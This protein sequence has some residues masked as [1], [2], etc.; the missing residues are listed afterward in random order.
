[1]VR[2]I[3]P[4]YF[5]AGAVG[6]ISEVGNFG[7]VAA[8]LYRTFG[9]ASGLYAGNKILHVGIQGTAGSALQ[10]HCFHERRAVVSRSALLWHY[11]PA[12]SIYDEGAVISDKGYSVVSVEVAAIDG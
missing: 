10:G 4:K 5:S 7:C 8:Y 6:D 2:S 11:F 1:G 12:I 3:V 9:F